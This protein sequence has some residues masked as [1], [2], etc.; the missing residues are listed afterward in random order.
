MCE[1]H[2]LID[3]Y[4]AVTEQGLGL[5]TQIVD[6]ESALVVSD[7]QF[8]YVVRI[9]ADDPSLLDV[10]MCLAVDGNE[11][12]KLLA[13]RA[14]TT[15]VPCLHASVDDDGDVLLGV[16]SMTGPAGI[17]PSTLAVRDLLPRA[18]AILRYAAMRAF[19]EATL[20]GIVQASEAP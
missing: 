1:R 2:R 9:R 20:I 7:G 4:K 5:T 14:V 13:C 10:A 8:T 11:D 12:V 15:V 16:Q 17:L 18:F 6:D 19:E 3:L